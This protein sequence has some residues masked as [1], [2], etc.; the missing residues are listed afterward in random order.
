MPPI[1]GP[2]FVLGMVQGTEGVRTVI[3]WA[4]VLAVEAYTFNVEV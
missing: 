1:K 3:D 4:G 2:C